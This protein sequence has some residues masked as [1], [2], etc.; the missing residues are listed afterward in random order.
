[1]VITCKAMLMKMSTGNRYSSISGRIWFST[2]GVGSMSLLVEGTF[3]AEL[4]GVHGGVRGVSVG[5]GSAPGVGVAHMVVAV[6]CKGVVLMLGVALK[7]GVAL[8]VGV[9]RKVGV[10]SR[11]VLSTLVKDVVTREQFSILVDSKVI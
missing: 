5:G 4:P 1:M 3:G 2:L 6:S 11:S 7:V 10:A 8:R 9:A